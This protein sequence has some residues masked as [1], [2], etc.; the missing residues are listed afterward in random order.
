MRTRKVMINAVSRAFIAHRWT[1]RH[2]STWQSLVQPRKVG[3]TASDASLRYIYGVRCSIPFLT[4][5]L[6]A[7]CT[8]SFINCPIVSQVSRC[9]H[10]VLCLCH[11]GIFTRTGIIQ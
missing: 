7:F 10:T 1:G 2:R 9:Y 11:L 4:A 5:S 3:Q 8:R 6:V